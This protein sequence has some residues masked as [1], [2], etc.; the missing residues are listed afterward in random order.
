M[1]APTRGAPG[2][3]TWS[4]GG[5]A[6]SNYELVACGP[7]RTRL[8]PTAPGPCRCGLVQPNGMQR[9]AEPRAVLAG[10]KTLVPAS[11]NGFSQKEA[12]LAEANGLLGRPRAPAIQPLA[13]SRGLL[14]KRG[15][16]RKDPLD[17]QLAK[18]FREPCEQTRV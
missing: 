5:G 10:A 3:E 14:E 11:E 6:R 8:T 4:I 7:R 15:F 13:C 12:P 9:R 2:H 17:L 16:T 18:T 1:Q